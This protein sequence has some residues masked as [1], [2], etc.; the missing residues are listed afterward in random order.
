MVGRILRII[1]L[2]GFAILLARR[3]LGKRQKRALNEKVRII[4]W[5]VLIVF[6]LAFVMHLWLG[7]A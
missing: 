2:V 1:L 7:I 6:T 4:A 5:V 3:L